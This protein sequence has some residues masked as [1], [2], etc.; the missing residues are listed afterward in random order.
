MFSCKTYRQEIHKNLKC[1]KIR[2][3]GFG[4]SNLRAEG[5][6]QQLL[7]SD[8]DNKKQKTIDAVLDKIRDKYGDDALMRG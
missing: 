3:L 4:V 1:S 6:G 8:P 7:F 2:L 5:S